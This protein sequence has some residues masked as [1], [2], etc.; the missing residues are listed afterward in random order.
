M[1]MN[2]FGARNKRKYY[3]GYSL[4]EMLITLVIIGFIMVL[5][6][7][8]LTAMI[9]ASSISSART[10]A[11]KERQ[12]IFQITERYIENSD[13]EE[14]RVFNVPD[15]LQRQYSSDG[16]ITTE[17]LEENFNEV[18]PGGG[19]G[20]E[21]HIRPIGSDNWIC[22]AVMQ[23]TGENSDKG[24]LLKTAADTLTHHS[25]CFSESEND[26]L[27]RNLVIFNSSEIDV[28]S[29]EVSSYRQSS[30]NYTFLI[31]LELEPVHWVAG[32]RSQFK[33]EYYGQ[34]VVT[35]GKVRY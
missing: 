16:S 6:S 10:L 31:N 26:D 23:G 32:S 34:L 12:F 30:G 1:K 7:A 8:T 20:N 13:P 35:T 27:Y 14:V 28:N 3:S 15:G 17:N 25:D 5:V 21:I 22:I 24:Y 11:R 18:V 2:K 9:K 29:F 19:F 33:P 4:V